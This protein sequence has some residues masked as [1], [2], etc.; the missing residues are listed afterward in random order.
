MTGRTLYNQLATQ[1]QAGETIGYNLDPAGRTREIVSTGKII[2][3]EPNTTQAPATRQP[4][5][6]KH[7]GTGRVRYRP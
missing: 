2:A 4:G 6:Q 5:P 3:T 7:P 1:K